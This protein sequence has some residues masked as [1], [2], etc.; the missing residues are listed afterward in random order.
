M[1]ATLDMDGL[2][3]EL[4]VLYESLKQQIREA[5]GS[6]DPHVAMGL[7][8]IGVRMDSMGHILRAIG[9]NIE[10]D[11]A[12]RQFL[13]LQQRF[14]GFKGAMLGATKGAIG[15]AERETPQN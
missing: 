3:R 2:E 9:H 10:G 5:E 13:K 1:K 11:E 7:A 8:V 15:R 4:E 6:S 12:R 14:Q